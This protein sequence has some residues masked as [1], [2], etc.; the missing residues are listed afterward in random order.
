MFGL[1]VRSGFGHG[2]G[3]VDGVVGGFPFEVGTCICNCFSVGIIL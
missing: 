2:R 1:D 3:G